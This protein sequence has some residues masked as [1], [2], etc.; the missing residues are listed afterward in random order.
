MTGAT[1][2][3]ARPAA[4][5]WSFPSQVAD[6]IADVGALGQARPCS[7][8]GVAGIGAARHPDLPFELRDLDASS[9]GEGMTRRHRNRELA[10]G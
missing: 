9:A 8:Q 3:I 5:I 4:T 1:V 2:V 6:D 10:L 7:E